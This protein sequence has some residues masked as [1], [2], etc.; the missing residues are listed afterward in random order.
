MSLTDDPHKNKPDRLQIRA[1]CN[2]I[3]QKGLSDFLESNDVLSSDPSIVVI[4]TALE[5]KYGPS[6]FTV[7]FRQLDKRKRSDVEDLIKQAIQDH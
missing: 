5:F 1:R 3:L 4:D 7:K 2:E 6:G